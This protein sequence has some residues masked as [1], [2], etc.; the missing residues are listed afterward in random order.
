MN[1]KTEPNTLEEIRRY[2][3][4]VAD[5]GDIEAI[6]KFKPTDATTNPTLIYKALQNN[7]YHSFLDEIIKTTAIHKQGNRKEQTDKILDQLLVRFGCE[8]LGIIDGRVSTEVNARLSFDINGTVEK[9]KKLIELYEERDISRERIL[10]KIAT[11]WEGIQAAK[12]L[13]DDGIR[14]NM[15]LLFSLPQAIACAQSEVQLISPFVGRIMDWYKAASGKSHYPGPDD[16]GVKSVTEIYNYYKK[17][18]HETE[19]MGASFRNTEE[20]MELVGCD[21]LTISPDLLQELNERTGPVVEKLTPETARKTEIEQWPQVDEK[22][23]RWHLNENQMATEKLSEGI[24]RFHTDA[25]KV[26][27]II[28]KE[29]G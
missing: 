17:Y 23:F 29:L 24:R 1:S 16:P 27:E 25:E 19:I 12:I 9:A 22:L 8:I 15:T 5:T 3:T 13:K 4:V 18:G 14:C 7:S 28:D 10:I 26:L 21:L 2:T 11:T 20:I 6:R